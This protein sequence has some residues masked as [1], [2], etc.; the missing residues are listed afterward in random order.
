MSYPEIEEVRRRL[1]DRQHSRRA[2]LAGGAAVAAAGTAAAA[3]ALAQSGGGPG[4]A[5]QSTAPTATASPPAPSPT[6]S[7]TVVAA[8]PSGPI[9]EPER[10]AAHLLRR[11][12]FG[13]SQAE[14]E[15]FARLDREAAAS[16]LVDYEA[17]DNS[18]LETRV[19]AG[20]FELTYGR[21][22]RL[23]MTRWW[24]T[25]MAYTERPLEERMTL[26]WHGWLVSQVSQI[27]NVLAN[28]MVRQNELFRAMALPVHDDLLQAVSK[29]P[30][31]ML[32][33]NTAESSVDHPNENY[34][35]EL[36]ELFSMGVDTYSE[37]DV[38]EAARAF[39]GWRFS[40]PPRSA[41]TGDQETNQEIRARWEP[42]F[43]KAPRQHDFAEKTFLGR[44]GAWDGEDIVRIIEEQAVTGE[45]VCTRLFREFVHDTPN[46]EDIAALVDVWHSSGHDIREVVRVILT[47]DVFYSEEAYRAKVRS[48][49]EVLVGLVRGLEV[50]TDFRVDVRGAGSMGQTL[51]DPPN[52]A[53][54]EGGAAW[55][56]SA[57]LFARANFIDQLFTGFRA[58]DR[59]GQ[60]VP[61][62]VPVALLGHA[63]PAAMVDTALA[64]LVDGN[65]PGASRDAIDELA[66]SIADERERAAAVAYLVACSPEYQLA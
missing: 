29:D 3:L 7:A 16:R 21:L 43:L 31:M 41:L 52:V 55:L 18:A 54:W 9:P 38:R 5:E 36:M 30:A 63:T 26:T 12:G 25:R 34:A 10:R 35:R 59:Q 50:E 24:L 28:Y 15:E 20:N 19:A 46:N 48:P 33:L 58:A 66:A 6:A 32:Y 57:T 1:W 13:G 44:V 60:R 62:V 23:D 53:G 65:V 40:Q 8:A 56:S 39:T 22:Q 47:S 14:I 37:D 27:P 2:V 11:A 61:G 45:F 4:A 51:Y 64:A 42:E 17:Q 49:V